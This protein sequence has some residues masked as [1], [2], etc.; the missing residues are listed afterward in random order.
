MAGRDNL[1][2][3]PMSFSKWQTEEQ[4]ENLKAEMG[5]E[6]ADVWKNLEE[7]KLQLEAGPDNAPATSM[8]IGLLERNKEANKRNFEI[9]TKRLDELLKWYTQDQKRLTE[10]QTLAYALHQQVNDTKGDSPKGKNPTEE[11]GQPQSSAIPISQ[12]TSIGRK[13]DYHIEEEENEIFPIGSLVVIGESFV[14]QVIDHGSLILEM[15]LHRDFLRGTIVRGISEDDQFVY[16]Q[17]GNQVFQ[18]YLAEEA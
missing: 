14:A 11:S 9:V 18:G 4:T 16:D 5:A 1:N 6:M 17:Y 7:L 3:N 8:R 10:V 12:L 2:S 13:G 15:P